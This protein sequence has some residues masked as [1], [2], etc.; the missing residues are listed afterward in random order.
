MTLINLLEANENKTEEYKN[1]I[2][3]HIKNTQKAW[4]QVQSKLKGEYEI[5]PS[6]KQKVDELIKNHD[7]S[8]FSEE[9]FE[10]YRQ[11]FYPKTGEE[12][13][14]KEF[15]KAWHHHYSVNKHHW[16]HWIG[17][18]MPLEYILEQLCDWKA[19]SMKFGDTPQTYYNK[20]KNRINFTQETRKEV[21]KW[22]K[23][24]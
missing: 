18:K 10:G 7:K 2:E 13:N 21:E 9:E 22:L 16:Q 6:L 19:M 11:F 5:S 23:V 12:K 17:K 20:E 8:K 14:K 24:F 1:Y 3:E 15:D 4:Q